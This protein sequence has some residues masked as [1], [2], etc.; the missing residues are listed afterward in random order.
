[1]PD[2]AYELLLA[3]LL[4]HF[5]LDFP[6]QPGR[7]VAARYRDHAA[8]PSL[9]AHALLHGVGAT[10]C[11][12]ALAGRDWQWLGLVLSVVTVSHFLTDWGKSF[13]P[14]TSLGAFVL[15]QL[16]HWVVL[17][18]LWGIWAGADVKASI[19]PFWSAPVLLVL[20]AYLVVL[21][22]L[23]V[24]VSL[25]LAPW[26]KEIKQLESENESLTKAGAVIGYLERILILTFVLLDEYTAIGFVLALKTAFRF[27]DTD[28][29]RK[30]EYMMMG[31]FLSFSLTIG[32]GLAVRYFLPLLAR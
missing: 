28:D 9:Y 19:A 3:L 30:A 22:P 11:F 16:L 25:G 4:V 31:T 13:L 7:W 2:Y 1:M 26:I 15:D 21:L 5:L 32:I 20:L 10:A 6:F 12:A 23:S 18:A 14:R 17:V 8:A 27:K 29:R 24:V